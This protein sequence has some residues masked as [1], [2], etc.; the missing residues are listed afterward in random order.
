MPRPSDLHL[1]PSA[2]ESYRVAVPA[3]VL[4]DLRLRLANARW[5]E[6]F[7]EHNW[8]HGTDAAALRV[9]CDRWIDG[10]DWRAQEAE[11]NAHPHLVARFDGASLHA[12]HVRSAAPRPLPLVLLHG[13]PSTLSEFR[14][15]IAPLADPESHGGQAADAF[16]L[17]V[18]SLPGFGFSGPTR[19]PGWNAT[20]MARAI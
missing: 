4:G 3:E 10:F 17:I 2:V 16:D 1:E 15:V 14:H 6:A 12:M 8:E 9:L 5:P 7:P 18:V 11:L 20:R 13:W 19:T